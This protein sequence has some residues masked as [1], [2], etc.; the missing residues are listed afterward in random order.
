MATI[1]RTSRH[2]L[3]GRRQTAPRGHLASRANSAGRASRRGRTR[4]LPGA[5]AGAHQLHTNPTGRLNSPNFRRS[6][7][8]V[9]SCTGPPPPA[10]E[11][12]TSTPRPQTARYLPGIHKSRRRIYCRDSDSLTSQ[13]PSTRPL[14]DLTCD[15]TTTD[16]NRHRFGVVSANYRL[17]ERHQRSRLP[18]FETLPVDG[19]GLTRT[20]RSVYPTTLE[21]E[22]ER[23]TPHATNTDLPLP[24]LCRPRRLLQC[25]TE[26][27]HSSNCPRT[28]KTKTAL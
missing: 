3:S 10:P 23:R 1:I 2:R 25:S 7:R 21:T 5:G 4:H 9:S 15:G 28:E 26:N 6:G 18:S 22:P 20:R 12:I 11:P 8:P 19:R 17:Y 16:P 13:Q 24:N 14:H 27:P